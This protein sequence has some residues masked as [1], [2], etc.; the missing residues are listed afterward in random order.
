ML[1]GNLGTADPVRARWSSLRRERTRSSSTRS[2]C[3]RPRA[4]AGL[5]RPGTPL[6]AITP[7]ADELAA[8]GGTEQALHDRGVELVW[9]RLGAAGSRLSGPDGVVERRR[10]CRATEVVDV[11]GAGDAMLA[12]FCHALLAG[13]SPPTRRRTVMR[14]PP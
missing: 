13:A 9:I 7:N 10:R 2:A 8:L 4:L 12:A 11:T 14:P 1:D 5:S 3:R 6:L